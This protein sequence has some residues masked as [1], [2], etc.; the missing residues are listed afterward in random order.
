MA[1]LDKNKVK[2]LCVRYG[3]MAVTIYITFCIMLYTMQET[4]LFIP[5]KGA[6]Y[7]TPKSVGL[8]FQDLMLKSGNHEINAW[9]V[10]AKSPKGTVLFCHGNAGN[11]A[12]RVETAKVWVDFGYNILLY[13]YAGYGK[14]TGIP[15]EANLYKD[16][17]T[18]YDWLIANGINKDEIIAHGRSLG[19]A[20]ASFIAVE[21]SIPF[22]I[23][24]STFTSVPDMAHH[25]FPWLP[26][27]LLC[28]TKLNTAE[29]LKSF[30]GKL[31]ILHSPDDEIIPY[32]MAVQMANENKVEII[33]L[34]G[35]HNGVY[36][37]QEEYQ[38]ILLGFVNGL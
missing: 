23:L 21:E 35:G 18:C 30:T 6:P 19:G 3:I 15:N 8:K 2:H 13:D 12:G 10:E 25:Q 1:S 32:E 4:M 33:Q 34:Q 22:L 17:K 31:K 11:L 5:E 28:K 36:D 20:S 26:T 38:Q 24:E 37:H 16:V 14:S 7:R 29:R 9:Y 27:T